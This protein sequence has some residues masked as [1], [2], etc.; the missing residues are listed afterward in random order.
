[1]PAPSSYDETQ[2]KAFMVEQLGATAD[3][4]ALTTASP[5]IRNGVYVA[6]RVCG[7]AN[8]S[9]VTD[10]PL[11]EAVAGWQA[12][13]A[14]VAAAAVQFN[15]TAGS[16]GKL[17]RSQVIGPIER[18]RDAARARASVYAEVANYLG[19]LDPDAPASVPFIFSLAHG[20]RGR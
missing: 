15:L 3:A 10:M 13:E 2:L 18:Q 8:V 12:W 6:Q 16:G 20:C 4:L 7:A 17:E 11:L 9:A 1:M 14:A 19:G 5:S